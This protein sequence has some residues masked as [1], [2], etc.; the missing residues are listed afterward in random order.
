MQGRRKTMAIAP[1]LGSATGKSSR[2]RSVLNVQIEDFKRGMEKFAAM[3]T[4][5]YG[6]RIIF[7]GSDAM[8]NGKLI[9]VPELSILSRPNMTEKEMKEALDFLTCTRGFVYHEGAHIIKTPIWMMKKASQRGGK[10][11]H[12]WNAIEDSYIEHWISHAYPGAKEVLVFMNGWLY[13]RIEA[14]TKKEGLPAPYT[15]VLYAITM[16]GNVNKSLLKGGLWKMLPWRSRQIAKNVSH[17]TLEARST[18]DP[19]ERYKLVEKVWELLKEE[20]KTVPALP[21]PPSAGKDGED[22]EEGGD[23]G[24][25]TPSS[26]SKKAKDKKP[27]KDKGSKPTPERKPKDKDKEKSHG[28]DDD[29]D[30]EEDSEQEDGASGSD[31]EDEAEADQEDGEGSGEGEDDGDSSDGADDDGDAGDAGSSGDDSG[32]EGDGED[33]E[34]S[35]GADGGDGEEDGDGGGDGED[36]SEASAS[37]GGSG[38]EESGDDAGSGASSEG[39]EEEAGTGSPHEDEVE[40]DRDIGDDFEGEDP[41]DPRDMLN[42]G[43]KLDVENDS[44]AEDRET[45]GDEM[46]E[47]AKKKIAELIKSGDREYRVY[48]TEADL[49]EAPPEPADHHEASAWRQY[50]SN[51]DS[52]VKFAYGPVRRTLE[53]VLKAQSR[54]YTVRGLEEGDLDQSALY[55]LAVSGASVQMRQQAQSIHQQQVKASNLKDTAVGLSIDMSGSMGSPGDWRHGSEPKDVL[56]QK[57]AYVFAQALDGVNIPFEIT[58]WSTGPFEGYSRCPAAERALYTRFNALYILEVKRFEQPWRQ[59]STN[60]FHVQHRRCN[61]DGE[62]VLL[63]ARRLM[64][65]KEKRK[66][67]FVMCD[68]IPGPESY[69]SSH[70]H[71]AYLKR[72]V[73]EIRTTTPIE[74]IGIGIAAPA[75]EEFYGPQFVNV[76]NVTE[77]PSVVLGQLRRLL[78]S[79][80]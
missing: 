15:Q 26:K 74:L 40:N 17:L 9:Y 76:S 2:A 24:E 8:T 31:A 53:N 39:D 37:G 13:D 51:L 38:D 21:P 59:T 3:Y 10:F 80:K 64:Q 54:S 29:G 45:V 71:A 49:I 18:D 63:A 30:A 12:L 20:D 66:V 4:E 35:A 33:D 19:H 52:S 47:E 14:A 5:N 11:H 68:G 61:Y 34:S 56:A 69:E 50:M 46:A 75:A 55:K 7:Q 36:E 77:L 57:A 44:D 43:K 65:R 73:N 16:I 32:G 23:G 67:L 1:S 60:L 62:S 25:K 28:K 41:T 79:K 78:V 48:S 42:P 6:V 22:G 58:A 72:V 27:E 70:L